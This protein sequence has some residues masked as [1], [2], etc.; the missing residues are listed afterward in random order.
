MN[1][2]ELNKVSPLKYDIYNK[3]LDP[4][5]HDLVTFIQF[6]AIKQIGMM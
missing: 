3:I 1:T 2:T 6:M 5:N 4:F